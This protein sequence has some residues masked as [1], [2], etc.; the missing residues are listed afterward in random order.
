MLIGVDPFDSVELFADSVESLIVVFDDVSA[1]VFFRVHSSYSWILF[2]LMVCTMPVRLMR[3]MSSPTG[4]HM[5][6]GGWISTVAARRIP[7]IVRIV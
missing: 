4:R 5:Y 1:C 6:S 2:C 3:I 7:P